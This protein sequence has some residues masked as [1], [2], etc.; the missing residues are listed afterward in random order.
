M[1]GC[2]E[3]E[4][5]KLCPSFDLKAVDHTNAGGDPPGLHSPIFG[6]APLQAQTSAPCTFESSQGK[7]MGT[8]GRPGVTL[9]WHK[10]HRLCP[11]HMAARPRWL[12][13]GPHRVTEVTLSPSTHR[14][15]VHQP[16]GSLLA[17]QGIPVLLLPLLPCPAKPRT[18]EFMDSALLKSVA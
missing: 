6:N 15:S 9:P 11:F 14:G 18:G 2:G 12:Q 16:V 3:Q 5:T 4:V 17:V 7:V 10:A 8:Q 13:G 1:P